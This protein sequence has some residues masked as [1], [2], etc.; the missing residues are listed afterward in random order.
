MQIK[1]RVKGI[2]P[3]LQNRYPLTEELRN[4][5]KQ[6]TTGFN[7]LEYRDALYLT[8][9]EEVYQP[10]VHLEQAMI[11]ASTGFKMPG[12]GKKTWKDWIRSNLIVQP[13]EILHGLTPAD[14]Q[15]A[16]E[17]SEEPYSGGLLLRSGRAGIFTTRVVIRRSA[18]AK[19]RPIIF[20]WEL[21]FSIKT[22][23][24]GCSPE[25]LEA[26]LTK[27]GQEIGIGDWRPRYGRFEVVEFEPK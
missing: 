25:T 22:L 9:T 17:A 20:D 7:L 5:K 16:E 15:K 23:D 18:I 13:D 8:V 4:V 14:F 26:I 24:D 27:A 11:K 2:A 12:A 21:P 10:A 19:P 1:V 6:R 3:L